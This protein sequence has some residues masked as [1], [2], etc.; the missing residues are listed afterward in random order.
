M[1]DLPS[2]FW[3]GWIIVITLI[4]LACVCWLTISLYFGNNKAETDGEDPVW[5]EDLREG[6]NAPPLW[7]F[8]LIFSTM[9]F[10]VLYMM[11]FPALGSYEGFFNWSQGSR[12][13]ES[14]ESF[15]QNFVA[16]RARIMDMSVV[17]LQN[18]IGLME[19]AERIFTR[20]C[21]ACHGLDGRGQASMFPNLHDIDWQW[22]STPEQIE[23]TIRN[24]RQA[25]M[26]PWEAALS[27]DGVDQVAEY[28][29]NISEPGAATLPGKANYDAFCVACHTPTG[30]GNPL[31]GAPNL[32]DD[33]WLYGNSPEAIRATIANGR[34]GVMPSFNSR[35]DDV[36]IK[37]LVALLAR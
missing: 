9:I 18:D 28:V 24:G 5:D 13:A 7:W 22:G 6:H 27:A 2:G 16:A 36:Q 11:L 34:T 15:D 10:S 21:A 32:T 37:L 8:W 4:S 3:S 19:T 17:E 30:T 20:E 23:Q 33:I 25:L 26:P 12:L 14:T 31:L 1:A 35:L 29:M